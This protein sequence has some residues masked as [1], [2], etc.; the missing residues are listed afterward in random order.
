GGGPGRC[1]AVC[2]PEGNGRDDADHGRC[3]RVGTS[4]RGTPD[5]AD[6]LRSHRRGTSMT[7]GN[8][9]YAINTYSYSSRYTALACIEHLSELGFRKFELMLIPG[10]FW[11][12]LATSA[13]REAMRALLAAR[14]LRIETINQPNLDVNLAAL[15]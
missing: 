7:Q 8:A 9:A 2:R 1:E 12:S 13:D 4:R 10:H 6:L 3:L 14:D 5:F 11:P 15:S